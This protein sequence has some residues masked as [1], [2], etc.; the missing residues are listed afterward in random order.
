LITVRNY[1]DS[2]FVEM[3]EIRHLLVNGTLE[4][5]TSIA[6]CCIQHACTYEKPPS[7]IFFFCFY[8][9]ETSRN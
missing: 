6:S 9:A 8:L 3:W 2:C 5:M 4:E 1:T 7:R